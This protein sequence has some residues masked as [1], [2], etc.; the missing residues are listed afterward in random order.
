MLTAAAAPPPSTATPLQSIPLSKLAHLAEL[1]ADTL[2]QQLGLLRQS[3]QVRACACLQLCSLM[4]CMLRQAGPC[5]PALLATACLL[6]GALA[7]HGWGDETRN[8]NHHLSH[9]PRLVAGPD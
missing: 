1:D 6:R 2:K 4:P 8:T 3:T 9:E 7:A 5:M